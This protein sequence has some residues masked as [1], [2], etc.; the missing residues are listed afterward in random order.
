MVSSQ[1]E[2]IASTIKLD[3]Q[4]AENIKQRRN[5]SRVR[6]MH[7]S[8]PQLLDC[9]LHAN[10]GDTTQPPRVLRERRNPNAMRDEARLGKLED[11]VRYLTATTH[12]PH[13]M[14]ESKVIREPARGSKQKSGKTTRSTESVTSAAAGSRLQGRHLP[15]APS[16]PPAP[17][18]RRLSTPD[19]PEL[20]NRL[21]FCPCHV[22]DTEYHRYEHGHAFSKMEAQRKLTELVH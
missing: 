21:P 2:H 17:R 1:H 14:S 8:K 4:K 20:D 19:L 16:P 3:S 10:K 5:M 22:D 11:R 13:A 12:T 18:P 6:Q 15:R 9:G 7:C